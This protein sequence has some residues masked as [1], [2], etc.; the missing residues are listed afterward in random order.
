[1]NGSGISDSD[2]NHAMEVWKQFDMKN[3]GDYHDL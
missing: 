3:M 1:M 2:Y